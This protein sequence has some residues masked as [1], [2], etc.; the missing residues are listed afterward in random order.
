[1]GDLSDWD[2]PSPYIESVDVVAS[3][4]DAYDH[5]NNAVYIGWL[6][7]TAWAHSAALGMPLARCLEIDRGMAVLRTEIVY[8]RPAVL[9]DRVNIGT[10]LLPGEIRLRARRRFHVRRQSDGTTLARA[11]IEYVCIELS[12]GRPTRTPPDFRSCYAPLDNVVA[13]AKLLDRL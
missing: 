8:V 1:M 3:D 10:W 5:V 2:L 4:I 7:R 6:D 12:S 13:A 9:G 11:E